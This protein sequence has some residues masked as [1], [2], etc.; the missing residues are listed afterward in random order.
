[1]KTEYEIEVNFESGYVHRI[2]GSG[3]FDES[4][5]P[6]IFCEDISEGFYPR[7]KG[8]VSFSKPFHEQIKGIALYIN[9][10]KQKRCPPLWI[11][12]VG[13]VFSEN[14]LEEVVS[15]GKKDKLPDITFVDPG[16]FAPF[17]NLVE[18]MH[19]RGIENVEE[20]LFNRNLK[21]DG[22]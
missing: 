1:M 22:D 11:N 10:E 9:G 4:E 16:I 5:F 17:T 7:D 18:E 15:P 12:K 19:K 2:N 8:Q 21:Q 20:I 3:I 14:G 6:Y 13:Y